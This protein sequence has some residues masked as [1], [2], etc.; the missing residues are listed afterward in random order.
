[1]PAPGLVTFGHV[2][3]LSELAEIRIV[4]IPLPHG[5]GPE[6]EGNR[7][8]HE[9]GTQR[10]DEEVPHDSE[11]LTAASITS[12]NRPDECYA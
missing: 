12:P 5:A 9:D 4:R 11:P 2:S 3:L 8:D 1:M 6:I 7:G 10:A